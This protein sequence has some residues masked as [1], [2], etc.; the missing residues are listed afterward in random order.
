MPESCL[1]CI[2]VSVEV[3][4]TVRDDTAYLGVRNDRVDAAIASSRLA[5]GSA[6]A[7][8]NSYRF[9]L[10]LIGPVTTDTA[11]LDHFGGLVFNKLNL[12]AEES[13]IGRLF[14]RSKHCRQ[15]S[16]QRFREYYLGKQPTGIY[17]A[18]HT[19]LYLG[20]K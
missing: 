20:A 2:S 18:S 15:I 6:M 19:A 10:I 13:I 9:A 1:Y 11:S 14:E 12:K 3:P 8:S 7:Y 17:V 4:R 16:V 5:T